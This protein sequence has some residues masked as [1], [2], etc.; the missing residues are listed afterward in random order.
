MS[1]I[2]ASSGLARGG[3][4]VVAV[5][6]ALGLVL[7]FLSN[8]TGS[9]PV[10]DVIAIWAANRLVAISTS[11]SLELTLIGWLVLFFMIFL[12]TLL[13]VLINF[14]VNNYSNKK[15]LDEI[16]LLESSYSEL[17]YQNSLLSDDLNSMRSENRQLTDE[18]EYESGS[19]R[20]L[21]NILFSQIFEDNL[22]FH[23]IKFDHFISSDGKVK[24]VREF[25]VSSDNSSVILIPFREFADEESDPIVSFNNF[26]MKV[27]E[28]R[29]YPVVVKSL[30][31][32]YFSR[33]FVVALSKILPPG[34]KL[35]IYLEFNWKGYFKRAI[36][37]GRAD[38]KMIYA[39]KNK[40]NDTIFSSRFR[41]AHGLT[42]LEFS[43]RGQLVGVKP[44]IDFD[45]DTGETIWNFSESKIHGNKPIEFAVINRRM[46]V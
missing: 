17:Q 46:R 18:I 40:T 32:D 2:N 14:I 9:W 23:D 16:N 13:F 44:S 10:I 6:A 4:I 30:N 34:V 21:I 45:P 35:T 7:S 42:S 38:Y 22:N 31:T 3:A 12:S 5:F 24:V 27:I 29:G 43:G 15:Y 26:D 8:I 37:H 39:A 19:A 11:G 41:L 33:Y 36:D 20:D 1:S 25:T 28:S